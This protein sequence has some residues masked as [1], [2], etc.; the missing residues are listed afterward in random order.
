ML[1]NPC[2]SIDFIPEIKLGKYDVEL[3][4]ELRLLGLIVRYDLKWSS[5]TSMM[6]QKATQKLWI[7][8]RLTNMGANEPDLAEM[9]ITQ[10]KSIIELADPAWHGAITQD[11][12]TYIERVKN[13]ELT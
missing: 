10:I 4:E 13:I 5:N 7:L 6:V 9:Y 1:F 11:E 12:R 8:R 3:V 2:T